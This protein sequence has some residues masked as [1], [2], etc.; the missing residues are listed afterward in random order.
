MLVLARK[1]GAIEKMIFDGSDDDDGDDAAECDDTIESMIL[2]MRNENELIE[3]AKVCPRRLKNKRKEP[4]NDAS[5]GHNK[6]A[7]AY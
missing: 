2:G 5:K 3:K 7:D 4:S 1:E 6:G